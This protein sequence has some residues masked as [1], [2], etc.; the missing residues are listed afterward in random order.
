MPAES[1]PYY[2]RNSLAIYAMLA[3]R[4]DLAGEVFGD[5]LERCSTIPAGELEPSMVFL[6]RS[7]H[8]AYLHLTGRS[9]E[10]LAVWREIASLIDRIAYVFT[11][12]LRRRHE[13]MI[14]AFAAVPHFDAA[15]WDRFLVRDGRQEV[16]P[17]W[18]NFGRGFRMPEI[19]FWR[20]T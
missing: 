2:L 14:D 12:Y 6:I 19:E 10:G 7:N 18:D 5:L 17:C 9:D 11:N 1:D 3:G 8:A 16:G 15:G 4:Y 13:L 20:D